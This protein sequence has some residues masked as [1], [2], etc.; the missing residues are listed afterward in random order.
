MKRLIVLIMKSQTQTEV[1][2][3][4]YNVFKVDH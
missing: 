4:G 3:L 2:I 1:C